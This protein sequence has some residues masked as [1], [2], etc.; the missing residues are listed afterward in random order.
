MQSQREHLAM[1][2]K[3]QGCYVKMATIIRIT[4]PSGK[5]TRQFYECASSR[6]ADHPV[7]EV[8]NTSY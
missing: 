6:R 2:R 7:P 4:F 1:Y 5:V 8:G 3:G